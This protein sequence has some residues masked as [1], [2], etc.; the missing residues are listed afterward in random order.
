MVTK[1]EPEKLATRRLN[2]YKATQAKQQEVQQAQG[3]GPNLAPGS[4]AGGRSEA[5]LLKDPT[6]PIETVMQIRARQK[7]GQ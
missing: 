7:A 5:E 4:P 3:K 6:T 2:D 1:E